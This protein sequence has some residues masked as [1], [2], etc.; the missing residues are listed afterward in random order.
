MEKTRVKFYYNEYNDDLF[1]LFLDEILMNYPDTFECYSH[2]GQHGS[3]HFK[4]IKESRVATFEEYQS[5][6]NELTQLVGYNLEV[7][8]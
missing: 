3:V 2:I 7:L 1:A 5:L 4:Y 6:Y 8:N